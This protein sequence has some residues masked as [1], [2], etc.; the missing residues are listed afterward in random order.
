MEGWWPR[1]VIGAVGT[2][3]PIKGGHLPDWVVGEGEGEGQWAW[4]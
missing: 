2:K 3:E 1:V 4:L